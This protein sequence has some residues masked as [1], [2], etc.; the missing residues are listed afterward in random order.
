MAKK[1]VMV[2]FGTRPDAI[3][4]APVIAELRMSANLDTVAVSTGQHR[5]MLHQALRAFRIRP[6]YSLDVMTPNQSLEEVTCDVLKELGPVM[7]VEKPDMVLVHGDTSTAFASA[8]FAYYHRIPVGHVEAGLYSDDPYSPYPEEMNRRLIS[9]L[10]EIHFAPTE[11]AKSNLVV[12]GID[13]NKVHVTGNTIADAVRMVLKPDYKFQNPLFQDLIGGPRRILLTTAH[14]RENWGRPLESICQALTELVLRRNDI[15]VVYPVHLHPNVERLARRS[16]HNI[17]RINLTPPLGFEEFLH[18]ERESY[19]ILTDSGGLQ[20]E[21]PCLKKP[22]LVLRNVT[23]R[24]D[25][26][27]SGSVK[28]VGTMAPEII[29]ETERLLDDPDEYKRMASAPNPYGDEGAAKRIA[30]HVWDFL[31]N[32]KLH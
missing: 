13:Q 20:E 1:K 14:R 18:L 30:R 17:D 31:S 21:A 24:E 5:E 23:E 29:R 7:E 9:D 25:G 10:S 27:K 32:G 22:V 26:L 8:L 11:S 12:R 19:L 3:K 6:D 2:V 28:L 15:E 16:L 4:M